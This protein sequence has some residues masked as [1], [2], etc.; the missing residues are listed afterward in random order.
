MKQDPF[1]TEIEEAV[2]KEWAALQEENVEKKMQKATATATTVG[3]AV[4]FNI[5][6]CLEFLESIVQKW[7][8]QFQLWMKMQ[9]EEQKLDF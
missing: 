3:A 5:H 9:S 8:P 2:N 1:L 6:K 7:K 4:D